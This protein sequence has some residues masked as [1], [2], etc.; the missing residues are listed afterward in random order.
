MLLVGS[1]AL[2]TYGFKRTPKDWDYIS[3]QAEYDQF[4]KEHESRIV[5]ITDKKWGHLVYMQGSDPIEIEIVEKRP[6]TQLLME[7]Y[8]KWF[9]Y[10]PHKDIAPLPLLY[11][12]KMSHR[13]LKNSPHFLKT[14]RDIKEMQEKYGKWEIHMH[15]IHDWF[16]MREKETYNYSHPSLNRKKKDFFIDDFYV[17]PH[18]DIH[19]VI[20]R[21][22]KPAYSFFKDD[23][24]IVKCSKHK[25][26]NECSEEIRL[27]AVL[28]EALVL[29]LERHQIPNNY[30][31]N[32]KKS[33][34]IS[35]EKICTGI[36][37]G[38]FREFSYIHYDDVV[39]LYDNTAY[40]YV[41]QFQ[42]DVNEGLIIK[43]SS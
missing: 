32:P 12:L 36:T 43:I 21:M 27:N 22:D 28:E 41:Q 25:F 34:L 13:F 39:A 3:T 6:S 8:D 33:F 29:S 19:M 15:V 10:P 31:P 42:N 23:E 11:A 20:A 38:W 4:V 17:Y 30:S 9:S 2:I 7:N 18:D 37:S 14:M 40:N 24:C 35:L 5:L 26:F 1:R 16:K